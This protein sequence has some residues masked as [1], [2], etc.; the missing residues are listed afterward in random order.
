MFF[1]A[2]LSII[3]VIGGFL[4]N[5][6][7]LPIADGIVVSGG[8]LA[9]GALM[10]TSVLFVLVER[11]IFVLRRI[12]F[13][14]VAV[15]VFNILLM[16]VVADTLSSPDTLNP[17]NTSAALFA[18]S[19]PFIIL[20]GTLIVLALGIMLYLFE[21]IKRA[22]QS[23]I[24]GLIAYL[25]VFIAI[26][27]LD[28]IAFPLIAFG[29]SKDVIAMVAGGLTGKLLTATAYS[30]AILTFYVISPTR[31][32]EYLKQNVFNWGTL[33]RSSS[34][35]IKSIAQKDEQLSR[36]NSRIAHSAELAGLGYGVSN[37]KTG[38][39]VD[40]DV[41]YA[42]M[43]GLKVDD[44][45]SLDIDEGMIGKIVHPDDRQKAKVYRNTVFG[46]QPAISELRYVMPD[47][48]V[49]TLRK[50][51]SPIDVSDEDGDLYEVVSQDITD[52]TRLQEQLFKSQKMDAIGN[53]TGGVAH[54]FNNLLAVI[55][56][57][58]ELLQD[59]I[60]DAD[61]KELL[62]NS[63]TSTL[64]GAELTRNMLSFARKAQLEPTTVDLNGL[65]RNMK[66]WI[67]R[68]LP[69]NIDVKTSFLE[70]L[71]ETEVDASSAEAGILN[72][73]L[74]A[75]DAMP[76]GGQLTIETMNVIV[77]DDYVELY[78]E[79][80]DPGQYVL[81]AISDTGEG[82]STE[83]LKHVFE[84]F[85]TTKP[86]GSGSGLGLSMIEGFMTQ[87]KGMVRVYSELGVGTTFKLYFRASEV[88]KVDVQTPQDPVFQVN[89]ES[90]PTILLVEDNVDV[91][92]A[93]RTTLTKLGYRVIQATS[94]DAA[95]KIFTSEPKID[96]LLTDIVMP[97][98]LQG[99]T[100]AKALRKLRPDLPVVFMSGYA[101]EATVHGNGLRPEDI[102]LMKPVRREDLVR[103]VNKGLSMVNK[104]D[105]RKA[106]RT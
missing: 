11:D 24:L 39:I 9:Y 25:I 76:D 93:I 3:L 92:T 78:D 54:D 103:A 5:L 55:L 50:I 17:H 96:L 70:E 49:R 104:K 58:L 67:G 13:L 51:F 72:L 62:K 37:R 44:I 101:S 106:D 83:N 64:R 19:I 43:H 89:A 100:L 26:L 10:M 95:F 99:T 45:L 57:N 82:I 27:C 22:T 91:L 34:D 65:I 88:A 68:T 14:V 66:N 46:M 15:N 35:I 90:S 86:V 16:I 69:S 42:K 29:T 41:A 30:M 59:E 105:P 87:S 28:G 2:Y 8:N 6:Y 77:D 94:G 71:W 4:G 38:K 81:V 33:L 61:Q 1:Y 52:T 48:D 73:I 97:G 98:E 40:C 102:R 75:R 56:G 84:P 80:V 53:L 20:G 85:F 79:E 47:G 18:T 63:I 60:T 7:S 32:S 74:N 21:L 12:V 31:F 23:P 36:T